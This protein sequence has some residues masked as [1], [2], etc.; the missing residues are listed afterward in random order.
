MAVKPKKGKTVDKWRKKK[1][2]TVL[3]PK[4]FQE[5]ELGQSIAYDSASL[6]G[7]YVK[8]NLMMLTGNI[9]K[10]HVNITFKVIRVQ[11]DTAFTMV[12]AYA[13][14]PSAIKRRVR[15]Q[16]DRI[17]ESF[18]CVTKDNR[19]VRIKPLVLTRIKT[20]RSVKSALRNALLQ[21]VVN[22]V[23]KVDY[24][25]LVMD[26]I[27]EKFQKSIVNAVGKIVPIRFVDIRSMKYLGEQKGA[28][29]EAQPETPEVK[30]EE[31]P[32]KETKEKKS[33]P[34]EKVEEKPTETEQAKEETAP[35]EA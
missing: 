26:V 28:S 2:F 8:T 21:Y 3:A 22:F 10:Q 25:S 1:Y 16:R 23:R 31:T 24:D 5:R 15:R 32:K 4:V 6:E 9:K 11:G 35:A 29:V 19:I 17:D 13:V 7:R 34:K 12:D 30:P 14:A 33:A 27:H 18:Q 20:S